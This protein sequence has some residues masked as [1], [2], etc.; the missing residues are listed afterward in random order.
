MGS[1]VFRIAGGGSSTCADGSWVTGT[2]GSAAVGNITSNY[3]LEFDG[4]N[5]YVD[6]TGSAAAWRG[7]TNFSFACWYWADSYPTS[8]DNTPPTLF[9]VLSDDNASRI[10]FTFNGNTYIPNLRKGFILNMFGGAGGNNESSY[11]SHYAWI[12]NLPTYPLSK[13][14]KEGQWNHIALSYTGGASTSWEIVQIWINGIKHSS[15]NANGEWSNSYAGDSS[16]ST[17]SYLYDSLGTTF[18]KSYIGRGDSGATAAQTG[19]FDGKIDQ[20]ATWDVSI[21]NTDVL[22]LF[23]GTLAPSALSASDL[24][25]YYNFAEGAGNSTT[26]DSSG[27]G[28]TG[29]LT[30]MDTGSC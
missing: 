24:I 12:G 26:A 3:A 18:D 5:D 16:I 6:I 2:T 14:A 21:T 23:S 28:Y 30:N 20:L 9:S 15:T 11:G 17:P 8:G 22:N 29:T 25:T 13:P 1:L 7:A 10:N 4:S 19:Y 27:N